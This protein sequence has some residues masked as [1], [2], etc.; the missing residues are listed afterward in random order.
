MAARENQGYLIAIIVLSVLCILLILGTVFGW[1]KASEY[2]DNKIAAEAS[3]K[4]EKT[5][6]EANEDQGKHSG[7]DDRRWW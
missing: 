2:S 5:L 6:R 4:L 7:N 1:S 3:L